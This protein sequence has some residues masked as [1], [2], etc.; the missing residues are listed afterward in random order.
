MQRRLFALDHNFPEPVR[1]IDAT[2][3]ECGFEERLE[4]SGFRVQIMRSGKSGRRHV[5]YLAVGA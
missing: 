1:K 4:K 2:F 5:V 3:P